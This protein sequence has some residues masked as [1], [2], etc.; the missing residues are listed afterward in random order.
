MNLG[1]FFYKS[2]RLQYIQDHILIATSLVTPSVNYILRMP[3]RD[4]VYIYLDLL[5]FRT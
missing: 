1:D 4:Q 2:D 5:G 3:D